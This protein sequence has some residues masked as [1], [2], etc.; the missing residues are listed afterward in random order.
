MMRKRKKL[1]ELQ[2]KCKQAYFDNLGD[3][4]EKYMNDYDVIQRKALIFR[5]LLRNRNF[6]QQHVLEIGCGTGRFSIEIK[7]RLGV[8]TV[9]DIGKKLV[10]NL[11]KSLNC[12]GSVG[13]ACC[14]PF[15]DNT[16][17]YVISSECIE[18]TLDPE[19]AIKEMC[20]V[21]RYG[22]YICF[23]TPNRLWYPFLLVAQWA[24]LRKFSGIEN[25]IFPYQAIRLCKFSGMAD[26]QISGCHILPFQIYF[27]RPFL[28]RMNQFGYRLYPL[29]INFGI[30]AQKG[31]KG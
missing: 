20:R 28:T 25:W 11:T 9:L 30:L 15:S 21:C 26:I 14:L 7:K 16:F 19:K 22:G 10:T 4:F 1:I 3:Q 8:L 18:H 31:R 17:D 2:E 29:M 27:L 5:Q 12:Y 24:G 23:T 13:D 6:E